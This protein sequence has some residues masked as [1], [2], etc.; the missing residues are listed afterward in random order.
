MQL[1]NDPRIRVRALI[2]CGVTPTL[3]PWEGCTSTIAQKLDQF[4]GPVRHLLNP[5]ELPAEKLPP[6][7][8]IHGDSDNDVPAKLAQRLHARAIEA[9]ENS[10]LAILTGLGH[11]FIE[12]PF[13]RPAKA[14]LE[15]MI[16]FLNEYAREPENADYFLGKCSES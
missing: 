14:A 5:M 12:Q 15:R 11:R 4:A 16:P 3:E 1:S 7:L 8:L 13:E 10:Q 9:N 2:A 6:L